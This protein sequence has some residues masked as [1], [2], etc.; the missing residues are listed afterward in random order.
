MGV[1]QPALLATLLATSASAIMVAN[2]V[3]HAEQLERQGGSPRVICERLLPRFAGTT[4]AELWTHCAL[5][6]PSARGRCADAL[7][8]LGYAPGPWP[9]EAVAAACA[10]LSAPASLAAEAKPARGVAAPA[11][12]PNALF[13]QRA[14]AS[15]GAQATGSHAAALD[16]SVRGKP[17]KMV[18]SYNWELAEQELNGQLEEQWQ[19]TANASGQLGA[20]NYTDCQIWA[21]EVAAATL[22]GID[23]NVTMV[24]CNLS[25]VPSMVFAA[26]TLQPPDNITYGYPFVASNNTFPAPYYNA[27]DQITN[28][29]YPPDEIRSYGGN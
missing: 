13:L 10:V 6:L 20:T 2:G 1:A 28:D 29:N 16:A 27:E 5:A 19:Q 22:Q 12:A 17:G 23:L 24:D 7:R 4:E 3:G 21:E 9:Q 8:A 15:A 26:P 18:N 11:G 25:S 14:I